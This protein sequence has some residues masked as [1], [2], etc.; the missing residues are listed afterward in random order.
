M[1]AKQNTFTS[2][3]KEAN[4]IWAVAVDNLGLDTVKSINKNKASMSASQKEAATTQRD[5]AAKLFDDQ[6]QALKNMKKGGI[7][8]PSLA[9]LGND[10]IWGI[11]HA[12]AAMTNAKTKKESNDASVA[13]SSLNKSLQELYQIIEIGKDTDSMFMN[14]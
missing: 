3:N 2:V 14:E 8:N 5:V 4:K 6:E 13:S 1:E 7:N 12:D 9:K 11:Y 10:L